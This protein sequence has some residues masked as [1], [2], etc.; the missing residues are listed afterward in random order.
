MPVDLNQPFGGVARGGIHD[1]APLCNQ[2]AE[3]RRYIFRIQTM[4]TF[5]QSTPVYG[6]EI[7]KHTPVALGRSLAAA[8]EARGLSVEDAAHETRIPARCL[9]LLEEGNIAAFGSMTYARSFM[10]AYSAFLDVDAT[11]H[12][13]ALPEKGVLGGSR[14]YRYLTHSHGPWLR[15]REGAVRTP[16][17]SQELKHAKAKPCVRHIPSPIPAGLGVFA[18]MLVATTMWGMHLLD[19]QPGRNP[20]A[21]TETSESEQSAKAPAAS[22]GETA[23]AGPRARHAISMALPAEMAARPPVQMRW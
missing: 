20:A 9:R 15:E 23:Q 17:R 7:C 12:L 21:M 22:K 2:A 8:R 19:T 11:Q 1:C 3:R 14:D 6:H 4:N 13:K 10:R 5:G 16:G 18:L